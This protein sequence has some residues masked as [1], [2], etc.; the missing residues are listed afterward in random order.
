MLTRLAKILAG[1]LLIALGLMFLLYGMLPDLASRLLA[2]LLIQRGFDRVVVQLDRPEMTSLRMPRLSLH[3][4]LGSEQLSLVLEDGRV[5]YDLWELWKGR[6][7]TV[8]VP[9]ASILLQQH[10]IEG[11]GSPAEISSSEQ[12]TLALGALFQPIPRLPFDQLF[13]DQVTVHRDR[14]SGPFRDMTI[15]GTVQEREHVLGGAL[16]FKGLEGSAYQWRWM[17]RHAGV[18]TA[19][20]HRIGRQGSPVVA[21]RS[22][23]VPSESDLRLRGTF[24]TEFQELAPLLALI[25]PLGPQIEQISGTVTAEWS[26]TASRSASVQ[27]GLVLRRWCGGS[28]IWMIGQPAAAS[29]R[30]SAFMMSLRSV[31]SSRSSR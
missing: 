26:G 5:E 15:S 28:S 4:D 12:P 14:A 23:E 29:S 31:M 16:T 17:G 6:V 22:E 30:N 8:V 9:R 24:Q 19:E 21:F 10:D 3:K 1:L 2:R 27:S 20:L 13:L 25:I 11:K 18:M 7:N